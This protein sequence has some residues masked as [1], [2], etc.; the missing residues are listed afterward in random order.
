[1]T[2]QPATKFTPK[3]RT[4]RPVELM[5][6][7]DS[8]EDM[9]LPRAPAL[10]QYPPS[11]ES[12]DLA[13]VAGVEQ[14]VREAESYVGAVVVFEAQVDAYTEAC[15]EV[16]DNSEHGELFQT[17]TNADVHREIELAGFLPGDP[18]TLILESDFQAL[19]NLLAVIHGDGGQ[20]V[21]TH[22]IRKAADDAR[23]LLNSDDDAHICTFDETAQATIGG[24]DVRVCLD[25]K[26]GREVRV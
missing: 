25:R 21:L 22:G 14:F 3:P 13:T 9:T 15:D 6:K 12:V 1:M 8:G 10:T 5:F 18:C 23:E 16:V 24:G 11:K 19:L 26:C 4:C 7:P 2:A 17:F 20:Y